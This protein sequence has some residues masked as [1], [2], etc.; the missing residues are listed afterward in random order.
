MNDFVVY[1]TRVTGI[2]EGSLGL[3]NVVKNSKIT[4]TI[5]QLVH[6]NHAMYLRL[7]SDVSV[8]D[9][10]EVTIDQRDFANNLYDF[11]VLNA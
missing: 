7:K 8:G 10:I 11:R 1:R 6:I 4:R 9:E 2:F 3:V 5:P